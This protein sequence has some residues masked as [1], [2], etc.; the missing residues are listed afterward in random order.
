MTPE[1]YI[2]PGGVQ[3]TN[4]KPNDQASGPH[5]HTVGLK[6][7][8]SQLFPTQVVLE[9]GRFSNET[10]VGSR[11]R[12]HGLENDKH[13][14]PDA[15]DGVHGKGFGGTCVHGVVPRTVTQSPLYPFKR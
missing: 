8:G 4:V 3:L 10:A 15:M 7:V 14:R 12:M 5:Q 2:R 9:V 13:P 11:F 1:I 6:Q